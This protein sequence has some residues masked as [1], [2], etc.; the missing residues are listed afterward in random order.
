ERL[1]RQA[2]ADLG[3]VPE[4]T[5]GPDAVAGCSARLQLGTLVLLEPPDA[6]RSARVEAIGRAL[7]EQLP[8]LFADDAHNPALPQLRAEAARL[9]LAG[10]VGRAALLL[11]DDRFAEAHRLLDPLVT[12]IEQTF[13]H[14][15]PADEAAKP[16][17]QR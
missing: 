3:K 8:R 11:R 5:P 16:Y 14:P 10:T 15:P 6:A 4:P 12:Q 2:V 9:Q 13:A 17:A 1:L 7:T